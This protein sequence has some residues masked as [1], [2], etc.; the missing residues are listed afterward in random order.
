MVDAHMLKWL[1]ATAA[2]A[3][4]DR[5]VEEFERRVPRGE[6]SADPGARKKQ[7]AKM[8]QSINS[9]RRQYAAAQYNIYQKAKF[10][11]RVK[12][13][14]HDAGYPDDFVNSLV[15]LLII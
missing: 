10:A 2:T 4:A 7:L 13:R 12:W 1:D 9:H 15:R 14:L 11:N 6:V 3:H 5:A 8:D